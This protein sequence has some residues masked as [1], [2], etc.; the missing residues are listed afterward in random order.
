LT[1]FPII[2]QLK[3]EKMKKCMFAVAAICVSSITAYGV[4]ENLPG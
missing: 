2:N 3:M 4:E 1:P